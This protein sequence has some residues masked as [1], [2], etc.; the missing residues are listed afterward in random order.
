M[1]AKRVYDNILL[2]RKC[3]FCGN[4]HL[5]RLKD[6]RLKCRHCHKIYSL[7]KLRKDLDILYHFYLEISARKTSIALGISYRTV[8]RKF[9][10]YM[11]S[12]KRLTTA[13]LLLSTTST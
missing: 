9:M 3:I 13:K 11:G 8:S 1:I 10:E 5:Y 12:M 7:K 2:G 6:K 4:Y